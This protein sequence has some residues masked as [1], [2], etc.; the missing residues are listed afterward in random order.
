MAHYGTHCNKTFQRLF[1]I[2]TS[3]HV[4]TAESWK[5][6]YVSLLCVLISKEI[7]KFWWL[8]ELFSK[9]KLWGC[10]SLTAKET[11]FVGMTTAAS[12]K[13]QC[14]DMKYWTDSWMCGRI[15]NLERIQDAS[16]KPMKYDLNQNW[17]TGMHEVHPQHMHKR[18]AI[19]TRCPNERF[20]NVECST[21]ESNLGLTNYL[22][23]R[24][25]SCTSL[26]QPTYLLKNT[27]FLVSFCRL[28]RMQYMYPSCI[29]ALLSVIQLLWMTSMCVCPNPDLNKDARHTNESP[30]QLRLN[31]AGGVPM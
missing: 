12:S 23:E 17:I 21:K 29:W 22:Q 31:L 26:N 9:Q 27:V 6:L 5:F 8:L 10:P 14:N 11:P 20:T 24:D 13:K 19:R 4:L 30:V 18:V 25:G 7:L 2:I 1:G 15:G 16:W 28:T 3:V